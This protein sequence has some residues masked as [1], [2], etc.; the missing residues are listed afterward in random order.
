MHILISYGSLTGNTQIVAE[1]LGVS[2]REMGGHE[3]EVLD[4]ACIECDKLAGYDLV[5]FG[6]S[7]W[8]EGESNPT[9]EA[10]LHNLNAYPEDLALV[11]C[12]LFGLGDRSYDHFCG[13][14]DHLEHALRGKSARVLGTPL[15][16][17][18]LPDE[19][20]QEQVGLW[21]TE[22]LTLSNAQ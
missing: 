21:A 1:L 12:A 6:A 20:M 22:I 18:G 5:I 10:F 19:T 8:G 14:V 13:V 11:K 3:V 17:D 7:T 4:Q 2:L 16:L 15:K 9:T